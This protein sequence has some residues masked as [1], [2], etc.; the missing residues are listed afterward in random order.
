MRRDSE[1]HRLAGRRWR[2]QGLRQAQA[3]RRDPEPSHIRVFFILGGGAV[4]TCS[5]AG[6]GSSGSNLPGAVCSS[7]SESDGPARPGGSSK[8]RMSYIMMSL[9]Q[10]AHRTI[11]E[12]R[13]TSESLQPEQRPRFSLRLPAIDNNHELELDI[14]G[15]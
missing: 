2:L 8:L 9:A 7:A 10:S 12:L 4:P 11:R 14:D 1:A 5:I 6:P 3:A 15:T 13:A